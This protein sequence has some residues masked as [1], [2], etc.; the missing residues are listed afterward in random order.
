MQ[1]GP[2]YRQLHDSFGSFPGVGRE[3]SGKE[4]GSRPGSAGKLRASVSRSA[5]HTDFP[6]KL[7]PDLSLDLLDGQAPSSGRRKAYDPLRERGAHSPQLQQEL[8]GTQVTYYNPHKKPESVPAPYIPGESSDFFPPPVTLT[9]E[10]LPASNIEGSLYREMA[11]GMV[12]SPAAAAAV[13]RDVA[14]TQSFLHSLGYANLNGEMPLFSAAMPSAASS[15]HLGPQDELMHWRVE[16]QVITAPVVPQPAVPAPPRVD[17]KLR[18][19]VIRIHVTDRLTGEVLKGVAVCVV[20]CSGKK[21]QGTRNV[22]STFASD[23]MTDSEGFTSC[24]VLADETYLLTATCTGY[25]PYGTFRERTTC[26]VAVDCVHPVA[27]SMVP[28]KVGVTITVYE[29]VDSECEW[30]RLNDAMDNGIES[31]AVNLIHSNGSKEEGFR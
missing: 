20:P 24:R 30:W 12:A 10:H 7:S 31:F 6:A 13:M 14:R 3:Y 18:A 19:G 4:A 5:V 26:T 23:T 2:S 28:I 27:L 21:R 22:G 17:H 8:L 25:H 16:N 15:W 1:G 29:L 11:P 9:S